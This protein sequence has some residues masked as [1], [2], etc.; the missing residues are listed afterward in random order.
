VEL[1][2]V[3]KIAYDLDGVLVPDCDH[4]PSIKSI[5]EF[6]AL[7]EYMK[8]IFNPEGEY[9]IITA[10]HA[11]H[12]SSTWTWCNKYLFPLPA[13][14]HHECTDE[15]PGSYKAGILNTNPDIQT[16]VES[17]E[18]IVN[19]LRHNVTTGCEIIHFDEYLAHHFIR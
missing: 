19:Y 17:D 10:R 14:L 5:D 2:S 18:G 8:P 11:Q 13:R 6:Y 9:A 12:R 15:T 16:Y 4:I 3:I 7:T 1:D